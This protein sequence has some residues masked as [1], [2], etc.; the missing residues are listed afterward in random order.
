MKQSIDSQEYKTI[1]ES[2]KDERIFLTGPLRKMNV[3]N[4]HSSCFC[5]ES[6]VETIVNK[7][8]LVLSIKLEY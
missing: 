7:N 4:F 3:K 1:H 8:P 2:F 6:I 5:Q